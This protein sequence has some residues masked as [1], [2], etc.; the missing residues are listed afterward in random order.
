MSPLRFSLVGGLVGGLLVALAL[1][2]LGT[3][4]N[5][6]TRTVLEQ[7][8][9]SAS[10]SPVSEQRAGA[11]LTA[12]QIYQ[13]DAPGVV[14]IKAQIV[15]Q[16]QS[17]FGFSN[18]Q[19]SQATG[20]GFVVNRNGDILTNAHVIEG[21]D[22]ITV[23]FENNVT[24]LAKVVGKDVSDDLALIKVNPS[25]LTLDPL[26]L[27]DSTLAQVGDPV[28]A[29]GN[30][31]G[32]DRTLTTGVVSAI[33]RQ[34]QA[35]NSFSISHVIQTDAAINP[36]N[37]G[38]P[39][40]NS[41][42]EVIGVTSQIRTSDSG[43][44]GNVGI[45]FAEPI[46][47]AKQVIPQLEKNGTVMHAYL[48]IQGTDLDPSLA[49]LHLPAS[50]VLVQQVVPGGPADRAGIRGGDQSNVVTINGQQLAL[51]GDIITKIDG[52]P[53]GSMQDLI[54]I[55]ADHKPGDS[56]SVDVLRNG[57]PMARSVVLGNRPTA[58]AQ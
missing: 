54:S 17:P 7:Q 4:G 25:G 36:G 27:G 35:P 56:V 18:Q 2:A 1:L 37:S 48:G 51:G 46:N 28:V 13:R 21:A 39:L 49:Q 44:G 20:S 55:I 10:G 32:L 12:K 31:F 33:Q 15:Q 42:G 26:V 19:Q 58:A 9:L 30:P 22:N 38:G 41:S 14:Q 50:G 5:G 43:G 3:T 53:V 23:Q 29:I 11:A 40:I 24:K 34:I 47:T 6:P 45:G 16:V 52:K 57:K 8:P